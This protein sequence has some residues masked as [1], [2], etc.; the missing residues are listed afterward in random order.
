M[1]SM[2]NVTI[3]DYKEIEHCKID[4]NDLAYNTVNTWQKGRTKAEKIKD[5]MLGKMAE[6]AFISALKKVDI[7]FYHSY[8]SFR[9]DNYKL[10]APFDGLLIGNL[11]KKVI[12]FINNSVVSDGPKLSVD[13][14]NKIRCFG[15]YTV[16]IKST[17]ITKKYKEKA[18]IESYKN[19]SD[20]QKM[21]EYLYT[22]D[23][24]TYPYFIRQ[25]NMDYSRYCAF[26][27]RK[28]LK[29]NKEG[30]D[31][32]QEVRKIELDNSIDIYVRVFIDIDEG[33]F[34]IMGWIDKETFFEEPEI[35]KLFLIG[36][37]EKPI[38]FVHPLKDGKS[39]IELKSL[40]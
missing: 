39:I 24:I 4:V 19:E 37:S 10:H 5:T 20:L 3:L 12:N 33:K 11:S 18:G 40:I 32:E 8:D 21:I 16:E 22:L 9:N 6:D 31:L 23:F 28:F 13:V 2:G 26:V 38:Y 36:K 1:I 27:E 25:G 17:R 14:K 29:S 34:F 7:G 35:R 15:G 30:K